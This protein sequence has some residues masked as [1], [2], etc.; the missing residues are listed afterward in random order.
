MV[1]VCGIDGHNLDKL[2]ASARRER[3]ISKPSQAVVSDQGEAIDK[4]N[5]D[6]LFRQ[7]LMWQE[8][9]SANTSP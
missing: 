1:C 3:P 2:R 4:A 6:V 9:Q 7:F 5:R 8:R